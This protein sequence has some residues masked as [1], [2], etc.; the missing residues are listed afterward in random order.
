MERS[1]VLNVVKVEKLVVALPASGKKE[2]ELIKTEMYIK[3]G[4]LLTEVD[5]FI[6]E[7]TA[8]QN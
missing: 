2:F 8:I 1:R 7:F 4:K 3:E 5:M 6:D